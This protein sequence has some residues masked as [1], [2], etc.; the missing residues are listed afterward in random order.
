LE[1]GPSSPS[2]FDS[3]EPFWTSQM[4]ARMNRENCRYSDCQFSIT[5]FQKA[6]LTT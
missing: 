3:V 5:E 4:V 2:S 6:E 1:D